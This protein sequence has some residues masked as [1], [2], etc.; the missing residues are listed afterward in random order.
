M[1]QRRNMELS[2]MRLM[3]AFSVCARGGGHCVHGICTVWWGLSPGQPGT[4]VHASGLWI[5]TRPPRLAH[6]TRRVL[7]Y[8]NLG[9]T[10]TNTWS[11]VL[12]RRDSST[13]KC[14]CLIYS[15]I[16][17]FSIDETMSASPPNQLLSPNNYEL[18]RLPRRPVANASSARS[19]SAPGSRNDTS[20]GQ[21]SSSLNTHQDPLDSSSQTTAISTRAIKATTDSHVATAPQVN[22]VN[23]N[24]RIDSNPSSDALRE[25]NIEDW[26]ETAVI[27][28]RTNL[29]VLDVAALILNKQVGE[30]RRMCK[31]LKP[32]INRSAQVYSQL[33]EQFCF[34]LGLKV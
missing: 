26:D 30:C 7:I 33:Q 31:L 17:C 28:P 1:S 2:F 10:Q 23:T 9:R 27:V 32:D 24:S 11:R 34:P 21:Q 19:R 14:F 3:V 29:T 6:E 5:F 22:R 25:D 20:L 18:S 13:S 8:L 4:W 12:K 15:T 16:C